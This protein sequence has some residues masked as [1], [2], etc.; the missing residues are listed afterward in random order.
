V[1]AL[2]LRKGS[3]EAVVLPEIGGGLAA[4]NWIGA[5]G[6]LPLMRSL[7]AGV[8]MPE[9]NGLA[10]YPLVPWS[11]RIGHGRFSFEGNTFQL[12]PNYPPEPYPIHGDGWLSGWSV[13]DRAADAVLLGLDKSA[14]SPFT[15]VAG[16]SYA[17]QADT[18]S[19][20]LW[21]ENRGAAPMP[22][23]LGLHPWFD[24]TPGVRLM[25]PADGMWIAGPDVLPVTHGVPPPDA[26][27]QRF[28]P[29][30]RR[31]VDNCFTGWNGVAQIRWEDRGVDLHIESSP[32]LPY[33]VLFCPPLK[34]VFCFEPVTH[35]I[36]AFNLP[37]P[38]ARAG[39]AVLAFGQRL[40]IRVTF[41]ALVSQ[42][43]LS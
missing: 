33:Y 35:P 40:S 43:S 2:H 7:P 26:S 10:C 17:L 42:G 23:G 21:A 22:F 24:R 20:E 1:P 37:E 12:A 9:P 8:T 29:L 18:L 31:L 25:A 30:P 5:G 6:P 34:P 4:F 36:D 14:S 38:F 15:Y 39:L 27:F 16:L 3:L 41:R 11:N 19:V 28:A 13:L 32:P